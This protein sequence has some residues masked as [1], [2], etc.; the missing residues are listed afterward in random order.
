MPVNTE[1]GCFQT[2]GFQDGFHGNRHFEAGTQGHGTQAG[3][4]EGG[5]SGGALSL[6]WSWL[7]AWLVLASMP[8]FWVSA[9]ESSKVQQNAAGFRRYLTLHLTRFGLLSRWR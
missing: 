3:T 7:V 5:I 1:G 9:P 8:R 4:H 6:A 2:G